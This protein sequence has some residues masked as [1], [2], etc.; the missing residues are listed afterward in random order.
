MCYAQLARCI[1]THQRHCNGIVPS[2]TVPDN[3]ER[4]KEIRIVLST[5]VNETGAYVRVKRPW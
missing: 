3:N 5:V 1:Q 4:S 2:T